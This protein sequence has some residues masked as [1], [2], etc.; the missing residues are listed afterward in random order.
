MA[1]PAIPG[2]SEVGDQYLHKLIQFRFNLP[3]L[4]QGAVASALA[5]AA[6]LDPSDPVSRETRNR[7]AAAQKW[8]ETH[9]IV[10]CVSSLAIAVFAFVF[11]YFA[12]HVHDAVHGSISKSSGSGFNGRLEHA[13]AEANAAV[14]RAINVV[15]ANGANAARH[16]VLLVVFCVG[17]ASAYF[18]YKVAGSVISRMWAQR[19][20]GAS[21]ADTELRWLEEYDL[22][23]EN[24]ETEMAPYLPA[25]L[26]RAKRLIN[27]QRL[28]ALIGEQ[29]GIFGGDPELT[30]RHLAQWVL[31]VEHWPWLGTCSHP[32][33]GDDGCPGAGIGRTAT[34]GS[35]R[36]GR[37]RRRG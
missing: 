10:L 21:G 2:F 33:S 23:R 13:A 18:A 36:R 37:T 31:I 5:L 19:R 24:A 12:T 14:V 4:D 6:Q 26:R 25:N 29:R 28:Y 20:P 22:S 16:P 27:H 32:R 9:Q 35:P 3:P 1:S 15:V 7:L 30:H 11:V 8:V 34:P 17:F